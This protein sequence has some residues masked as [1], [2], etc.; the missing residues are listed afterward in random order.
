MRHVLPLLAILAVLGCVDQDACDACVEDQIELAK[1]L[2]E[3]YP[4][5]GIT[6]PTT[7][8]ARKACANPKIAVGTPCEE[9]YWPVL[10]IVGGVLVAGVLALR[11]FL[12]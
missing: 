7:L 1:Q 10:L 11:R 4:E 12:R 3:M 2:K 6:V 9:R 8:R 5:E